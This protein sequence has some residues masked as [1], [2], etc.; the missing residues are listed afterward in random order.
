MEKKKSDQQK[1]ET[2]DTS[3]VQLKV[4]K[5]QTEE[6]K[7][8]QC[9]SKRSDILKHTVKHHSKVQPS[10]YTWAPSISCMFVQRKVCHVH[11]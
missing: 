9:H 4:K 3:I 11:M 8:K 2:Y 7:G 6:R 5:Q 10:V 1:D